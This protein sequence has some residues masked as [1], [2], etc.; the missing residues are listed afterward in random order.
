V[1]EL[2]WIREMWSKIHERHPSKDIGLG[3]IDEFLGVDKLERY[4]IQPKKHQMKSTPTA[5]HLMEDVTDKD[6]FNHAITMELNENVT[7]KRLMQG[8]MHMADRG[9]HIEGTPYIAMNVECVSNSGLQGCIGD[10]PKSLKEEDVMVCL[11]EDGKSFSLTNVITP[12]FTISRPHLDD[13]GRGQVLLC[14]YGVKFLFWSEDSIE[15][16]KLFG[17]VHAS[18]K[19]DYTRTAV[20]TWPGLRWTIL[21]VGEYIEMIPGTV[22]AV[23]SA[24][25]SAVTGW[26]HMRKQWLEDGVYKEMLMWEIDIVEKRIKVVNEAEENPPKILDTIEKEMKHWHVWLQAGKLEPELSKKLRVLKIEVEKRI[27]RLHKQAK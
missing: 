19:G 4:Y 7:V 16:R 22:H 1:Q 27:K 18:S 6:T 13:C 12:A 2:R 23:L 14:V 9:D 17:E 5:K 8:W 10:L 26:H 24:E 3:I 21:H 15:L 25:N 11:T 20:R